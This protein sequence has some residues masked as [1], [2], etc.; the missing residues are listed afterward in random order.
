MNKLKES[1][2]KF[3]I[4]FLTADYSIET[5]IKSINAGAL[6]FIPKDGRFVTNISAVIDKAYQNVKAKKEREK[7]EYAL[8]ESEARFKILMEASK[9]GIF[10]WNRTDKT[11]HISYNEAHLLGFEPE[12]YPHSHREFINLIFPE[13]REFLKKKFKEHH[14]NNTAFYEAEIRIKN[15]DGYYKWILERGKIAEKDKNGD[16][17]KI[18]GTHSDISERK[19]NEEKI[20][21]AN[22]RLTTL[23]SNLPGIVYQCHKGDLFNKEFLGGRIDDITGYSI[24]EFIS[25][26][27]NMFSQ[28]VHPADFNK[29][30]EQFKIIYKKKTD[31]EFYYRILAKNGEIR[32]ILDHGKILPGNNDQ[33]RILEGYLA[34][35]TEKMN[36]EEALMQSEEEKN[37]ILDNSLQ[38][39]ILLTREGKVIS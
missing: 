37:I 5:A 33:D 17:I 22:R 7:F 10:E 1:E 30:Q 23:I 4:I 38:A 18:I 8:K 6:E 31:Y 27:Q 11:V 24:G 16:P 34:D 36:S 28:I 15:K 9:D 19:A 32:W 26:D 12:E 20:I 29:I 14:E 13:D 21:E 39:L 35:I 2:K 25:M 3:N